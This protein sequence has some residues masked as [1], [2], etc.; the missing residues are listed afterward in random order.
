M[1]KGIK[2]DEYIFDLFFIY[3][4]ILKFCLYV[5]GVGE[6][7]K[8]LVFLLVGMGFYVMVIDWC[9]VLCYNG[10]FFEVGYLIVGVLEEVMEGL[11]IIYRDF[12]IIMIYS[13]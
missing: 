12:I 3:Q 4:M 6:D 5:F 11:S 13:F 7:V 9:F 1:E 10:Y 2:K 8:L